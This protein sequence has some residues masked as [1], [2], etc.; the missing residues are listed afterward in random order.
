M[1]KLIATNREARRDYTILETFEAGLILVGTE[2]KSLRQE[3]ASLRESFA[4]VEGEEV[5]LYQMHI[6]P[7]AQGNQF[8]VDPTRTR[9]LLLHKNEVKRL[10]GLTQQ[11]GYTLVP[12]RLYFKGG[13]A[14]VEVALAKGKRQYDQREDMKRRDAQREVERALRERQKGR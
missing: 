11:K 8:N 14:K 1:D 7:Y 9:K 5:R 10:I 12:L 4:R 3:R 2:V 13:Y 6:P